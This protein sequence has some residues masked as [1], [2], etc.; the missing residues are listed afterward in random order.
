MIAARLEKI[1]FSAA[2]VLR[3]S[4]QFDTVSS[5]EPI[6]VVLAGIETHV[7]VQQSALDLV[8]QGI[9]VFIGMLLCVLV[10]CDNSSGVRAA[11][12]PVLPVAAETSAS[13]SNS[14]DVAAA[15]SLA[16]NE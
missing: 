8:S 5:P 6:Q 9:A 16:R 7:C 12:S 10:G 15:R 13:P 1:R 11:P 3:Q 4:E 2:E 14:V